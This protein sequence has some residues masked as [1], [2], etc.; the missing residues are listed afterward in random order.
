MSSDRFDEIA[1]GDEAEVVR[2]VTADDVATFARLTGD[3]NPLHMDEAFAAAT[4]FRKRVVHGMLT[5]SFLSTVIGTKLPGPGA[6]WFEQQLRF[7]APVR[8]GERV[9]VRARVLSKSAAARIITLA[10]DVFAGNG[11]PVITGEAK[12]KV[13][14]PEAKRQDVGH[15]RDAVIISGGSRG[16]GAAV[17]R[18][19]AADGHPVVVGFAASGASADEV[20]SGIRSSGGSAIAVAADVRDPDAIRGLVA[21]AAGEFGAIG[22]VVHC[23]SPPIGAVAFADLDWSAVRDQLDVQ[24]QGAFRLCKEVLPHLVAAGGGS[25]VTIGSTATDN[26]PPPRW[27]PYCIAK[28]ALVSFTKS[29]AVELGPLGIRVNCVAPG[30]TETDLIADLPEKAKMLAKVQTPLRRLATP[31]DVAGAVAFLFGSRAAHVT[32]EVLRVCGG[33]SMV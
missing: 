27:M 31:E 13:L 14:R 1:V 4:T 10:T 25:I 7:L 33:A 20:A 19:L 2:T 16:I 3:D 22:G 5:A 21:R 11:R 32:G 29:L 24:V 28:A 30:M 6:L 26:V 8:I 12:V 18:A 17:A 9:T 23:A 15:K